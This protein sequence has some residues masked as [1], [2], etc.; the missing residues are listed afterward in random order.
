[1]TKAILLK[2]A[3]KEYS[4]EINKLVRVESNLTAD[5]IIALSTK[6]YADL[7]VKGI[8]LDEEEGTDMLLFQYG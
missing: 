5:N 4:Q 7:K 6:I 2:S 1:M 3:E 8:S